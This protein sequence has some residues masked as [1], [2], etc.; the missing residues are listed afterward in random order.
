MDVA[1]DGPFSTSLD[2]D[3]PLAECDQSADGID[4]R[5]NWL[6]TMHTLT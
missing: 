4:C 2:S 5:R 3:T 1:S 6:T